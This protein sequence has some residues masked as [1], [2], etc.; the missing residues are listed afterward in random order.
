MSKETQSKDVTFKVSARTARLI[1]RENV[2]NAEAAVIELVKMAMM[3]M[4]KMS[5]SFLIRAIYLS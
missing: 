2:A 3:Q 4:Q 1:G 5:T